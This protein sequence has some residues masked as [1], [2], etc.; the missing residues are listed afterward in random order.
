[1][2]LNIEGIKGCT[3]HGCVFGHPGGMG[4]N[5]GC[6]C[7]E[8]CPTAERLRVERNVRLLIRAIQDLRNELTAARLE[9]DEARNDLQE[10]TCGDMMYTAL[11]LEVDRLRAALFR[12]ACY[13]GCGSPE[14][15]LHREDCAYRVACIP[16]PTG[17]GT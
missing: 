3:D 17:D 6:H 13:C 14:P 9:R 2:K 15:G 1:M 11:G 5:G 10:V 4:T 16:H 7:L 12:H 8:I